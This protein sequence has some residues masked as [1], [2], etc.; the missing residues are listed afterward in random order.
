[1]YLIDCYK[2]YHKSS[3]STFTEQMGV[4]ILVGTL[5]YMISGMI[6]DS[7]ITV[8]PLFWTLLGVGFAC[9]RMVKESVERHRRLMS[10]DKITNIN[11]N[12]H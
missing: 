7:T 2:A 1:M 3:Y 10:E 8:A 12:N 6:N 5:G 4:L 11:K 9:N